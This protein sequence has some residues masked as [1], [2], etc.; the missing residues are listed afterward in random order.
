MSI[1]AADWL[2]NPKNN[3]SN[4]AYAVVRHKYG[5]KLLNN[6]GRQNLYQGFTSGNIY[7]LEST[8]HTVS[9]GLNLFLNLHF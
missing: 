2:R 4:A 9:L 5:L 6:K 7:S 8:K 1:K 3:C